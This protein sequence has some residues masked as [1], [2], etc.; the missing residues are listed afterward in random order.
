MKKD[1]LTLIE[2]IPKIESKFRQFEPSPG[3]CI[4]PGE[5]I[6]DDPEFIEWIEAVKFELQEIYDRTHN[7][8]C[9]GYHKCYWSCPQIQW[10]KF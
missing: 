8:I 5:F 7:T 9:L 2:A 4:P 3:L 10:Q 1:L 6:Y